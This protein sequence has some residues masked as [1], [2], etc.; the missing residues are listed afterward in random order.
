MW[1]PPGRQGGQVDVYSRFYEAWDQAQGRPLLLSSDGSEV[2]WE[3]EDGTVFAEFL[4][5][6]LE[7][8]ADAN[9]DAIIGFNEVAEY[10]EREVPAYTR[11]RFP[12]VQTPTRRYE[13]GPVRGDIPL[14]GNL[15]RRNASQ[16]QA[17]ATRDNRNQAIL[18]GGFDPQLEQLSLQAVKR[19]FARETLTDN[20]TALFKQLDGIAAGTIT[21]DDGVVRVQ[22]IS[23]TVRP[24]PV[25]TKP[26]VT[27]A[28][29]VIQTPPMDTQRMPEAPR[30][31]TALAYPNMPDGVRVD[32][33]ER[34]VGLPLT[35]RPGR[36]AIHMERDGYMTIDM[37]MDLT[38][39]QAFTLD[40]LWD[41]LERRGSKIKAIAY[42]LGAVVSIAAWSYF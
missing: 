22:A 36:H 12:T 25:P 11:S 37:T 21:K 8:E 5:R 29:Q 39:D 42:L 28:P 7:G 16:H 14:P 24:V 35:L 1:N 4:L 18:L 10:L 13:H 9:G 15:E 27:T 41:R 30:P 34:R 32:V 17:L 19:A 31:K 40:P 38:D 6:G 23:G 3:E 2:S 33:D 20:E 26:T